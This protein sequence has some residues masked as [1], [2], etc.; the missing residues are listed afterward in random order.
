MHRDHSNCA[1]SDALHIS[2]ALVVAPLSF[3][4]FSTVSFL[5]FRNR[6]AL[7]DF[8]EMDFGIY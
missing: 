8:Y 1:D 6:T 4:F 3:S 5:I 2:A 7:S